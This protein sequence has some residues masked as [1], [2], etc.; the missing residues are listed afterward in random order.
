MLFRSKLV[1]HT[2]GLVKTFNQLFCLVAVKMKYPKCKL[3]H[4]MKPK[5]QQT[6]W[7]WASARPMMPR[8]KTLEVQT[9]HWLPWACSFLDI[10]NFLRLI[11][12]I[13]VFCKLWSSYFRFSVFVDPGNL[14]WSRKFTK[15]QLASNKTMH[16]Q[17]QRFRQ[18]VVWEGKPFWDMVFQ[19]SL[20][21]FQCH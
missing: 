7:V 6:R 21:F 16:F 19:V 14:C 5:D 1:P 12:N 9:D 2:D 3:M 11:N 13:V 20:H 8:N 15:N 4:T 18:I 17:K 10:L